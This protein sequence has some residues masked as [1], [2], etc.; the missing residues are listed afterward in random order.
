[1]KST[2]KKYKVNFLREE[3]PEVEEFQS[4]LMARMFG[5]EIKRKERGNGL[6]FISLLNNK[7]VKLPL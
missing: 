6:K 3:K 4:L 5:N 2:I 1:M 7:N